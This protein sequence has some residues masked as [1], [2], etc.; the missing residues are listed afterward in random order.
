MGLFKFGTFCLCTL[1]LFTTC[2]AR[3][4]QIGKIYP[5]F[6]ASHDEW[7]DHQGVFL[8]S[9]NSI[10]GLRFYTSLDVHLFLLVVIH[11][12]SG[13]VVWTANRGGPN[14]ISSSDKFVFSLNGNAYLQKGKNIVWST[15]TEGKNTKA[16]ELR[17]SGNLVLIDENAQILWQSFSHPTDTLLPGQ[18]FT[19]GMRLKSFPNDNNLSV[20]LE[21]KSGDLILYAGYQTPQQYWSLGNDTRKA[22]YAVNGDIKSATIVYNSWNFYDKRGVLLS[23]FNFSDNSNPNVTWAAVLGS[24][25]E[26][27]FYNLQKGRTVTPEGTKIPQSTCSTPEPCNRYQV[28]YFDNWCQCPSPLIQFNCRPP[29]QIPSTCGSSKDSV[30]LFEVGEKLDYFALRFVSPFTKSSLH[31]CQEACLKNCSCLVL[32]FDN[33]TGS[34]YMFDQ[35]GDYQRSGENSVGYVSFMKLSSNKMEKNGKI[36]TIWI[37]VIVVVTLLVIVGLL[38]T[39]AFYYRK[40]TRTVESQFPDDEDDNFLSGFPGMPTR[41]SYN[42]LLRATENFTRK[43]GQGG[44]GSVY[45]GVLPDGTQLAVKQLEGIA[46]C[47]ECQLQ[48]NTLLYDRR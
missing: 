17:N 9:N 46:N 41:F 34:C 39:G 47:A 19:E 1:A 33:N 23:Q 35:I 29:V 44:F 26:I 27:S 32:F 7:I 37:A 2:M 18:A 4:Q 38:Y 11:I 45:L 8:L 3:I 6:E 12:D 5:G 14:L 43:V 42:E 10:F 28:C 25:G 36:Q 13:K 21:L 24:K 48:S 22:N 20:F 15:N 16:M 30:K 31:N 40:K